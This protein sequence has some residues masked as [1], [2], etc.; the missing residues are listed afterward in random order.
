MWKGRIIK[1]AL[2]LSIAGALVLLVSGLGSRFGLW[3]FRTG[4]SMVQVGLWMTGLAAA[5]GIIGL[6]WALR[7]RPRQNMSTALAAVVI[8]GLVSS[9]PLSTVLSA[10]SGQFPPIHDITTDTQEPPQFDA[11]MPMRGEDSNSTDYVTKTGFFG[12][13]KDK[14]YAEIQSQYYPDIMPVMMGITPDAA[15]ENA[16][17]TARDMGW[18]IVAAAPEEGRIEATATTF[19]FGFKDDVIIRLRP[20]GTGTRVDIRS[21]SRVGLGDRGTNAKRI[22]AYVARLTAR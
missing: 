2:F 7:S 3:S 14:S 19:W 21:T 11:V 22:R 18:E 10:R 6:V 15:F 1:L 16:V 12:P 17:A 4:F 5:V 9:I 20:E 8:A 13:Y